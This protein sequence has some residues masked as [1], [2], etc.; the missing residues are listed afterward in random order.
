VGH[1]DKIKCPINDCNPVENLGMQG[2]A[3]SCHKRLNGCLKHWGIL[4]KVYCHDIMVHGT[5]FYACAVI[6]QLAIANGEPLF[7]VEYGDE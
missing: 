6:T 7:Q 1:A 5:V 3:R 4:E 2:T